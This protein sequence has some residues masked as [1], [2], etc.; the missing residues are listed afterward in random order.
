[1]ITKADLIVRSLTGLNISSEEF[2]DR[3]LLELCKL[4]TAKLLR[5]AV[6]VDD[7]ILWPL[8]NSIKDELRKREIE[9]LFRGPNNTEDFEMRS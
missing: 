9:Y 3:V 5:A 6:T 4:D 7:E 2:V 8:W 1:M